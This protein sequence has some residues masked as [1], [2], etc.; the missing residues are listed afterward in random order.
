MSTDV[1]LKMDRYKLSEESAWTAKQVTE[2]WHMAM[3][4]KLL[5]GEVADMR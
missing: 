1:Q 2:R 4:D 5:R 3:R